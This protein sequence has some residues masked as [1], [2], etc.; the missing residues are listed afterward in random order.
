MISEYCD[1]V[2]ARLNVAV[3]SGNPPEINRLASL[4]SSVMHDGTKV[5]E[6]MPWDKVCPT[7][8]SDIVTVDSPSTSE[9]KST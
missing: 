5:G 2:R 4:L 6:R 9:G 3:R 8:G 1:D 7:C